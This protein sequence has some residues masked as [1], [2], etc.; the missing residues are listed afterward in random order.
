[1][2]KRRVKQFQCSQCNYTC[3]YKYNLKPHVKA[4]HAKILDQECDHCDFK[5]ALT[6]HLRRHVNQV[7]HKIKT[8]R[9]VG[10][11]GFLQLDRQLSMSHIFT[12]FV[13]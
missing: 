11:G 10:A 3:A 2:P 7:H 13:P 5:T 1:M 9:S 4:V 12:S 8:N 6:E